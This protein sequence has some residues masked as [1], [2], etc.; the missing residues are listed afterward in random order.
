VE[1][2]LLGPVELVA[3]GRRVDLGP[4]QRR[5]VLAALA[6]DAGRLVPVDTLLDRVWGEPRPDLARRSL[7]AHI[8]RLRRVLEG[9]EVAGDG[10]ARLMSLPNGYLL[11]LDRDLVDLHRFRRLV[12]LARDPGRAD[13]E[14]VTLLR[15]ALRLWR[16]APLADLSGRW[17]AG[18]GEG[19][20]QQHL[21]ATLG[22]ARAELRLGD[23]EA[24][25]GPLT[26]LAGDHP[27]VEPLVAVL[28]R[29]LYAAGHS[30]R[31]LAL[32]ASARERLV[33][34]LGAEPGAEL[35]EVH[36]G[37]LRGEAPDAGP[38]ALSTAGP[39]GPP[40]QL[41]VD[42]HAFAGRAEEL[43]RLDAV[44]AGA[45]RPPGAV[46]ISALSGTAG[47]GKTALAVHWAHRVRGRFPDGQ[48]YAN[49]RG[50]DPSGSAM[51]PAEVVRGFL[52]ALSVPPRRVPP[53][54]DAQLGLY[55][56]LVA[57][58]RMLIVLDNARDSA[59][60][61]PLLPGSP[62]C[63]VLVTSRSE[64]TGLVAG[65]AARPVTVD[66]L[67][68][69]DAH[70]LLA[71]RLGA[72]RLAAEPQAAARL[73]ERCA[74]LPLALAIVAARAAA[75]PGFA[76][77]AIADELD[78][79]RDGL[80]AFDLGD[81]ATDLRA[82]LSYSYRT[83]SPHAA[84]LVRSL[85]AHPGPDLTAPA[86]ASLTGLPEASARRALTELTRA[87]LVTEQ[88]P[89]RY[90]CHDLLRVYAAELAGT[91]DSAAD[92]DAARHRILDHYLHTAHAAAMLLNPDRQP[93]TPRAPRPGVAPEAL[94]GHEDALAWFTA[95]HAVLV[96]TVRRA[97]RT[98]FDVHAWQLAWA[99][100][101]F[102]DRRGHWHDWVATQ[103][104]AL[105]AA[106]RLA[107][108]AG[109][110]HA[111]R[112]LALA[113]FRLGRYDEAHAHLRSALDLFA[114]LADRAGQA[115]T[116]LH[117]SWLFQ[118]QD[119][120][121]DALHHAG[122]ALDL[123]R[124]TDQRAWLANALNAVGWSHAQLGDHRQALAHC[125]QA[126]TL[127]QQLGDRRTGEAATWDSVGYAHQRLGD[128]DR[129]AMCYR[130][131]VELFR[132]VGDRYHE[133]ETLTRLG[134]AHR[135]AG[136]PDPARHAWQHA[137]DLLDALGHTE[138]AEVRARLAA[139]P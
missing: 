122:Q 130:Q 111:D 95:E 49:L 96:A 102:L 11:D 129:A 109:Q 99:L 92:R 54:L 84:R 61:R 131:A 6:V 114:G 83:L 69:A 53:G 127:Y 126:L 9:A 75:R 60:V 94:A 65:E 116:H 133:A 26:D 136:E 68:A 110:A 24:V 17:A 137:L 80:D 107:D 128:H 88:V 59:Q 42:V 87:H 71:R 30:A 57:D 13:A 20:R 38:A 2:R 70:D 108:P 27:L 46:V 10:P 16:G 40:A 90:G 121:D 89:G 117:L 18:V 64:L 132:A 66:L 62:G 91:V 25:I 82:V 37:V 125:Q 58:R 73:V 39:A 86:A 19:W 124:T 23:P 32:Y 106:R 138:A 100:I 34:E 21:D 1:L 43:A 98:G 22:W 67:T 76:L 3:G 8:A 118:R 120:H 14:R 45:G 112:G 28:M 72:D 113:Y 119:R 35:R 103:R 33:R 93:I 85:A 104:V 77:A 41:P 5:G 52:D 115:H 139:A 47:V 135:A 48:L 15:E 79:D 101:T 74:R 12:D 51:S 81:T 31:A 44:L 78:R 29:A 123:F 134:D 63:L 36:R 7:H 55:R 50:F 56:S 97:A 4:P 105:D